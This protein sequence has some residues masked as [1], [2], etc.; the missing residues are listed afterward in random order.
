MTSLVGILGLVSVGL[1]VVFSM[2]IVGEVSKLFHGL[3]F[4][5]HLS[6]RQIAPAQE[7]AI[8]P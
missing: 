5:D 4:R 8:Q 6:D 1:G 2:M 3:G 7:V